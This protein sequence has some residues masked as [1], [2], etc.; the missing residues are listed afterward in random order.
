MSKLR[1]DSSDLLYVSLLMAANYFS[2]AERLDAITK[3]LKNQRLIHQSHKRELPEQLPQV[4]S[5]VLPRLQPEDCREKQRRQRQ[6][7]LQDLRRRLAELRKRHNARVI[8]NKFPRLSNVSGYVKEETA[9]KEDERIEQQLKK[10]DSENK[11]DRNCDD[12]FMG[13]G[14]EDEDQAIVL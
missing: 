6:N 3:K 9:K 5:E 12:E 11:N 14:K 1:R 7:H 8:I 2:D 10:V 4:H 13:E